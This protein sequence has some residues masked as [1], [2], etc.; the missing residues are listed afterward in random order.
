MLTLVCEEANEHDPFA[1]RVCN[2][3]DETVGYVP[4]EVARR[5]RENEDLRTLSAVVD[6]QRLFEG[7]VVGV[8]IR[9]A[10]DKTEN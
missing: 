10:P 6:K 5:I 4:A 1:I 8:D 3:K 2:S 7:Q 9:L